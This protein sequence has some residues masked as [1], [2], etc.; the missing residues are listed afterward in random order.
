[1][2]ASEGSGPLTPWIVAALL[3]SLPMFIA[4]ALLPRLPMK[5]ALGIVFTGAVL[6]RAVLLLPDSV[7]SDDV[8][9]YLWDGEVQRQ[10]QSPYGVAPSDPALDAIATTPHGQEVRSRINHA[11]L[12]TVYPPIAQLSFRWFAYHELGWRIFMVLVD[13]LIGILLARHLIQTGRD[14]SRVVYWAWHPLA[15]IECTNGAH[16]TVLAVLG[17]AVS[18]LLLEKRHLKCSAA[19]LA[20]AGSTMLIPLGATFIYWKHAGFK[21]VALMGTV[22]IGSLLLYPGLFSTG[23]LFGLQSYAGSWYSGGLLLEPVGQ[24]LGFDATV[25]A[26]PATVIL[27]VF[28]V[29]LWVLVAWKVRGLETW[30]ATRLLMLAFVLLT[31]TLHPWYALWLLLPSVVSPSRGC[32]L[33]SLT[34]LLNYRVLDSWRLEGIWEFPPGTRFLVFALPLLVLIRDGWFQRSRAFATPA[35]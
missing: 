25:S 26:D 35:P 4:A 17:L 22:F 7:F 32:I 27:R 23:A 11:N 6:V 1:M 20:A 15:I 30:K 12:P 19:F 13:L 31:P 10:G 14:P 2:P 9:R 8:W 5:Q 34:A 18:L 16:V 3:L 29:A 28:L 24:L 33:L 21:I